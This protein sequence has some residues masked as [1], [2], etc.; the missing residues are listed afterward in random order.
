MITNHI[1]K[2]LLRGLIGGAFA[3]TLSQLSAADAV[4]E[5]RGKLIGTWE[6]AVVDGDAARPGGVR[7]TIRE[8][9]VSADQISA[10]DGDGRSL[11]T[12]TYVLGK[13]GVHSTITA[14]AIDG[15]GRGQQMAGIY[16]I[17]GDTLLWCS[18]NNG[19]PRPTEFRTKTTGA[20]LLVLKRKNP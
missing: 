12:G 5:A 19:N 7:H 13:E 17:E 6:G 9:V 3:F 10:R 14:T 4:D 16:R 8:L 20:Y 2:L 11:G 15:P 1:S 18:A